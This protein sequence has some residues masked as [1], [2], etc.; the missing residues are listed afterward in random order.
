L[1]LR[2]KNWSPAFLGR[3]HLVNRSPLIGSFSVFIFVSLFLPGNYPYVSFSSVSRP[4]IILLLSGARSAGRL[5]RRF[6]R[7]RSIIEALAGTGPEQ[8]GEMKLFRAPE[9][10]VSRDGRRRI[11]YFCLLIDAGR[12]SL[13][14]DPFVPNLPVKRTLRPIAPRKGRG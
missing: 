8:G 5:H 14:E 1:P 13:P 10:K 2:D 12:R 3:S 11:S 4:A 9:S 7:S 6:Q